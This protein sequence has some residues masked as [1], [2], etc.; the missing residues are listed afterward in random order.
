MKSP[1]ISSFA[2]ALLVSACVGISN[3]DS[4]I[5]KADEASLAAIIESRDAD[6]KARD[7][8]RRPLETLAYLGVKSDMVIAEVLPGSGWYTEILAPYIAE[9][10]AI[11]GLNY[12]DE[13]WPLF[14]FFNAEQIA[15][16]IAQNDA[17]PKTAKEL[18]GGTNIK[19]SS[20][21]FGQVAQEDYGTVDAVL[22]IRALHNLHRFEERAGTLT[23]AIEDTKN[24]LKPGGFVGV[25]QHWAPEIATDEWADG[26]AGYLKESRIIEVF[27]EAGFKLV[28][29]STL[30]ANIND[31]PTSNDVVWRLPPSLNIGKLEGAEA[32]AEKQKNTA[33]G[34]SNRIVLKF[35]KG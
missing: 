12:A 34:E 32:E 6:T 3:L 15:S 17:F 18:A 29:R 13:T 22:F 1:I 10:G 7:V 27:E 11:I 20:T 8:Y 35:A 25:V 2:L 16:T 23:Q 26:S 30:N 9:Q 14:G 24:L 28:G 4:N 33:I 5:S 19:A 21:T 31:R